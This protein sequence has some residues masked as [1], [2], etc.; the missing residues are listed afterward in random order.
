MEFLYFVIFFFVFLVPLVLGMTL[1]TYKEHRRVNNGIINY[2]SS[3]KKFVYKINLT[4]QQAVDLLNVKNVVDELSC[5]F[6]YEKQSLDFQ[7]A[8]LIETTIF[9][10]KNAVA[11]LS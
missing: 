8:D 2:N 1:P 11:F 4:Y 10:F 7:N 6:D 9:K 3:M 5:T